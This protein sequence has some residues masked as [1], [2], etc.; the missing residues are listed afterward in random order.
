MENR[1]LYTHVFEYEGQ[2]CVCISKVQK[3][4]NEYVAVYDLDAGEIYSHINIVDVIE[5]V[6]L[7]ETEEEDFQFSTILESPY[8]DEAWEICCELFD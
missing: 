7:R 3:L 2:A 8:A 5:A 4:Y 6:Q 1:E